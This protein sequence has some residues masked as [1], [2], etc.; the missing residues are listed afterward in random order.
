MSNRNKMTEALIKVIKNLD[1]NSLLKLC[2]EW[3]SCDVCP[4]RNTDKCNYDCEVN[5]FSYLMEGKK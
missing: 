4:L 5:M 1:D 2:S 3:L